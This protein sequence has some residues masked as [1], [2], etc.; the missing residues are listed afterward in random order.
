MI[1]AENI[2]LCIAVPLGISIL[3]VKGP[4]R[5][6]VFAFLLGMGVCLLS[7]YISGYLS[8]VT[9]YGETN[10]SIFLSPIIEEL[11]KLFPLLFFLLMF[12]EDSTS[13][14]HTSIAIGAGF[15]TF[16]NCCY[17]LNYGAGNLSYV[18]IRGMSVGVM[19]I[20]SVFALSL[21][22]LISMRL[23]AFSFPTVVGALSLSMTFHAIYN[24]LVSKPGITSVIG[25]LMPIVTAIL[26]SLAYRKLE[27]R[28]ELRFGEN[29]TS[30]PHK[31]TDA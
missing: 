17:I 15:A 20:M 8:I 5:R 28:Y 29:K 31:E 24:L 21:W 19:H 26:L 9:G 25:Y 4:V 7:A 2:L 18:I 11:M 22:F 3:F 23:K 1:Y 6:F 27:M 16:E 13:I 14:V 30:A 10:T 12:D